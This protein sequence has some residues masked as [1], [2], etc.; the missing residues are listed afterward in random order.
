M[1]EKNKKPRAQQSRVK[2]SRLFFWSRWSNSSENLEKKDNLSLSFG[3]N[4][5]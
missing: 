3:S 2:P 5:E 4:L 1:E